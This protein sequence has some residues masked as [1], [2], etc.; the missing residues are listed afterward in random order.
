MHI[1]PMKKADYD[2]VVRVLDRWWGGPATER[3]HPI[4]YYELG[5]NALVAEED[6]SIIGFL[7]GLLAPQTEDSPMTGYIHLVGIDPEHRRKSVG[8]ALYAAFTARV[9][10]AGATRIKAISNVGNEASLRFHE[11]LGFDVREDRDYAGDGFS[12]IVFT[13]PT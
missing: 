9:R 4:F 8:K 6:G 1:R 11:A 5:E 12:R 7:V 3:V 10:A 13:K 2:E